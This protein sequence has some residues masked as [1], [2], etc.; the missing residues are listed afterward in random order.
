MSFVQLDYLAFLLLVL[1]LFQFVPVRMRIAYLLVA[2]IVFYLHDQPVYLVLLAASSLLDF[3]IGLGLGRT[4]NKRSRRWLL[5]CSLAGNL[6]L[7]GVFKYAGVFLGDAPSPTTGNL[8]SASTRSRPWAT[9]STCFG[10]ACNPAAAGPSTPCT[11]PF[12]RSSSAGP[13]SV[14]GTCFRS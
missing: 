2:S 14:R 4:Q 3:G 10:G 13:S 11:S 8:E 12:S 7:L 5:G 1:G 6:G 9:P